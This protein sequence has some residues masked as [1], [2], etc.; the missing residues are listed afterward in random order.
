MSEEA[1]AIKETAKATQE[2]AK[3]ASNAI[4]AGRE[5]GGFIARFVSGPLEQCVGI[6]EDKLKYIRWERQQRLIKRSEE[7][8]QQLGLTNPNKLIPLKNAIP[9]LQYATLEEDNNLQDL[10]ARLLV[11]GTNEATGINIERAFIEI[12]AQISPLEAQILQAIYRLPFEKTRHVGVVTE[13]LPEF[14]TVAEKKSK[15]ILNEPSK[16]VRLAL[17]NLARIGCLKFTLTLGGGEIFTIIN[18]TL[19]GKEF[20]DACSFNQA[21]I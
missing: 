17:A 2:V 4:D 16:E 18:P 15:N 6:F 11:N 19:I 20:V 14:A 5:M 8:M 1:E 10:W 3:T 7:F 9:L 12:L 13:N 21:A